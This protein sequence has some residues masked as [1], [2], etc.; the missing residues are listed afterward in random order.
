MI[1]KLLIVT[2]LLLFIGAVAAV[3]FLFTFDADQFRPLVIQKIEEQIERAVEI[4][5]LSLTW[6]NGIA[7]KLNRLAIYPEKE[8]TGSPVAELKEASVVV[9]LAPLLKRQLEIKS[10][11]LGKPY[12]HI[13]RTRDGQIRVAGLEPR[14][15]TPPVPVSPTEV[16]SVPTASAAQAGRAAALPLLVELFKLEDGRVRYTDEKESP[17]LDLEVQDLDLTVKNVSFNRPIEIQGKAAVFS[18]H[19]NIHLQGRL[20]VDRENLTG[21]LEGVSL[22]TDLKDWQLARILLA[23]PELKE[24]G[25][26]AGVEGNFRA[27]LDSLE[28]D[29]QGAGKFS[30]QVDLEG[31]KIVL[32][33]L[34]TP[35]ENIEGHV[36]VSS[37]RIELKKLSLSLAGG[38]ILGVGTIEGWQ[39]PQSEQVALQ[40]EAQGLSLEELAVKRSP[41]EPYL[42]G[43]FSA[44]FQG[45]AQGDEPKDIARTLFGQG[46][47]TISEPVLVNMNVIRE[48]F[49]RLSVIPR[50]VERLESRLP[51]TYKEKLEA[52]DTVFKPVEIPFTAQNGTFFVD[53]LEIASESFEVHG[54]GRLELDRTLRGTAVLLIDPDLSN[55]LIRSIEELRYLANPDGRLQ[56]PL[57]ILGQIPQVQV[58]PDVQQVAA[59]L[60]ASKTREVVSGFLE[61]KL[62]KK[63]TATPS[64]A[65]TEQ[66][67]QTGLLGQL[68][69][70][71][72]QATAKKSQPQ[73]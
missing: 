8:K 40:V 69:E 25:I 36:S 15:K 7:L 52:K 19:Q 65:P 39:V 73:S 24:L 16:G 50:L 45:K 6:K 61:K 17:A 66:E 57:A 27:R 37:E 21:V 51:E 56:I 70:E 26:E 60:A 2:L 54:A 68:L 35:I 55:A 67:Q 43:S 44:A 72:F 38:T 22:E 3:I 34:A 14:A 31:G 18:D 48:V 63:E 41:D 71:A 33:S 42:R 47:M 32:S 58:Y 10:I 62:G 29:S 4:D 5:R 1:K 59:L 11:Y 13:R 46:K 28:F 23:F 49:D 20:E 53:R 12:L 30:S 9:R 64:P